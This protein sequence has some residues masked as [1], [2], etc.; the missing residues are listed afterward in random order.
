MFQR[1]LGPLAMLTGEELPLYK[2]SPK[3]LGQLL[4]QVH[5]NQPKIKKSQGTQEIKK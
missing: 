2:A 3:S 1:P 4:F 5:K